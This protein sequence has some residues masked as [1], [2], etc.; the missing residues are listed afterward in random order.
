MYVIEKGGFI[1]ALPIKPTPK[2]DVKESEQFLKKM[3]QNANKQGEFT[4]TPNLS[5]AEKLI[6]KY[7][8][9]IKE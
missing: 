1:M 2:L 5:E 8:Q 7:V 9:T 6:G 4:P 3:A